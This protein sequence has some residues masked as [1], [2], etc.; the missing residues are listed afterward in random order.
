V[1]LLV[2]TEHVIRFMQETFEVRSVPFAASVLCIHV[3]I[4]G[5]SD[6][7]LRVTGF[8]IK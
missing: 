1:D 3:Q 4:P 6:H 8:K 2:L 5:T 7:V